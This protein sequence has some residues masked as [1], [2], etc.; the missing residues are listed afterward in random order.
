MFFFGHESLNNMMATPSFANFFMS[1][2]EIKKFTSKHKSNQRRQDEGEKAAEGGQEKAEAEG[3]KAEEE[4]EE[5]EG[6]EAEKEKRRRRRRKRDNKEAMARLQLGLM[7]THEY[8]HKT[9]EFCA[10]RRRR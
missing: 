1:K 10:H 7:T 8:G 6:E 9:P 3:E 4:E 5:E 2:R